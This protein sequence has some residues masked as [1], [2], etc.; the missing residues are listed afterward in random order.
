MTLSVTETV[1]RVS[2]SVARQQVDERYGAREVDD[3]VAVTI[4]SWW[5][6]TGTLGRAH[7]A[8]ATGAT[9]NLRELLDEIAVNRDLYVLDGSLDDKALDMLGTWAVRKINGP[10][11]TQEE[12][13]TLAP[14]PSVQTDE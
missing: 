2:S 6:S 10:R 5:A 9:C 11:L 3:S 12:W 8:L 14:I 1:T 13:A 7:A 4:A